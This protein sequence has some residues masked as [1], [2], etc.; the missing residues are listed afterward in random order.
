MKH[1]ST[2]KNPANTKIWPAA[3]KRKVT[4]DQMKMYIKSRPGYPRISKAKMQDMLASYQGSPVSAIMLKK[5]LE[6]Q[7]NQRHAVARKLKR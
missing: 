2:N 7:V 1:R 5:C 6:Y 3:F 4:L